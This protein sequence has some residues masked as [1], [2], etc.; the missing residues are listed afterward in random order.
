MSS[1]ML[2]TQK[3]QVTIPQEIRERF[4]FLPYTEIEFVVEKERVFLQRRHS[5][6][7]KIRG[8]AKGKFTTEEIM[9]L[10]RS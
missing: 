9:K 8:I 2:I 3:G 5:P 6:F 4:G 1:S 7:T 10:T